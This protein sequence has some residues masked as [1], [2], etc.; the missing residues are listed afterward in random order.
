[1]KWE[2]HLWI[3]FIASLTL[4]LILS[5]PLWKIP[6]AFIMCFVGVLFPDYDLIEYFKHR[7]TLHNLWVIVFAAGFMTFY[8][9]PT[10]SVIFFSAGWVT[11]LLGDMVTKTGIEFFYPASN[12]NIS[13]PITTGSF[14]EKLFVGVFTI[15][16]LITILVW[17]LNFIPTKPNMIIQI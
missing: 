11:H 7:K 2:S 6:L 13:G 9:F 12:F 5:L 16:C 8:Q 17:Q 10:S 14:S 15:C 1:M 3:G 4:V